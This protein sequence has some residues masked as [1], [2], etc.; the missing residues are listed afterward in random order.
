VIRIVIADNHPIFRYALRELL[1]LEADF[2]IVGEAADGYEMLQQVW[3]LDPD[4]LLLDLRMPKLDGLAAL[5]T[6]QRSNKRTKG[7]ILTAWY[8]AGP[9]RRHADT[10]ASRIDCAIVPW[11]L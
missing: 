8:S 10:P 2:E 3:T 9:V 11:C 4:V 1:S 5:E 6:L 7:I